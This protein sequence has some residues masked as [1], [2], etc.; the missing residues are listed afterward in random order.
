MKTKIFFKIWLAI[1]IM[2]IQNPLKAGVVYISLDTAGVSPPY[3]VWHNFCVSDVDSVYLIKPNIAGMTGVIWYITN[4]PLPYIQGEDTVLITPEYAGMVQMTS[5]QGYLRE[6]GIMFYS[7][8]PSHANFH[9]L[10]GGVVNSTK[11]TLWMCENTVFLSSNVDGNEAT[12]FVWYGPDGFISYD[13]PVS[14]STPGMYYHERGN[15]CGVVRDT[16][17]LIKL[18]TVIPVWSDTT[19]CN[20]SVLLT[21]DPGPGWNYLW[22]TGATTQTLVVSDSGFYK[23][24]LSNQCVVLDSAWIHV[25]QVN[26]PLPDLAAYS[27]IPAILCQSEVVILNPNAD[28]TYDTY[29]WYKGSTPVGNQPTLTVDYPTLGEGSYVVEVTQGGCS[30]TSMAMVMFY[31]DPQAPMHC[32]SSFDPLITGTNMTVFEVVNA[33]DVTEYVLSYKQGSTWVPVDTIAETGLS[34][35][36][37]YDGVNDPDQ[38]SQTY[39]VFARH[40]CGNL[41][42]LGDWHKT[43]RI[44]I[45]QDIITGDYILQILDDYATLS[46]YEPDFYTI[47]IDSLNNGNFT[48]IGILNG[49][50]I[51]FTI[52]SPVIGAAYYI[53]VNLPW[54]CGGDKSFPVAFSNRKIFAIND[55]DEYGSL[56][57]LTI[58]PNPST[59]IFQIEGE[60]VSR[61]EVRD[62]FGRLLQV[63]EH[64]TSTL[65]LSGIGSGV[66]NVRISNQQGS[67]N[68]QVMIIR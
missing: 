36:T 35:Y 2:A 54:N 47:W 43:I 16:I 12:Y 9:C 6:I 49:G 28:H 27:Q 61:V 22:N 68:R 32:V 40:L 42:P 3:P 15:P 30:A 64:P 38:Q 7:T 25:S 50:N 41:S 56:S 1:F 60:S 51:S 8:P 63:V 46:G 11:D 37:L 29:Q 10:A 26:F 14:L 57:N 34:S 48:Q 31:S 33:F 21:L 62:V 18:P 19:F 4:Y 45:F 20:T 39:A 13:A 5:T 53:S 58:Y 65:D 23:V 44:G 59:G 67:T 24:R 52:T 55:V 17:V 66:Y